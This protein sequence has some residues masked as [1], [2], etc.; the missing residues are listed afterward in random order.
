MNTSYFAKN[1]KHPNAVAICAKSPVWYTGRKYT[2]VAPT[3]SIFS[4]W[5]KSG[6]SA[7][8]TKRF[9]EEVLAN[10][11]PLKVYNELGADSILLCYET[12]DKFCHR[13]IVAGW[14]TSSLHHLGIVVTEL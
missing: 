6:D 5:K 8:Y 2:R 10:L 3:W 13:H 1:A 11:D 14:L 12:P 7:L 4:E 9:N